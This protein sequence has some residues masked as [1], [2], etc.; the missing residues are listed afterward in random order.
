MKKLSFLLVTLLLSAAVIA[1]A[2][3]K[4]SY[5]CVI[6]NATGNLITNQAIG[7]KIS[8]IKDSP[9]GTV[10]YSETYNPNPQ[11]NANGL[12]TV[13]I[14]TG[15]VISGIF[16]NIDWST[17]VF[18]LKT[19]TDPKGG[20]DYTIS[21][22]SPLLSVPYA[23]FAKTSANGFSGNYNDLINKPLLFSGSYND[24]TNKPNIFDG[25]WTN[26]TGKPT[27]LSGYGITDA[28]ST[29]HSANIISAT[30][31][32]NWNTAY[33]WGNHASS[34][35]LT[36][37]TE[38]DPIFMVWDKSTG[39]LITENQISD[40]GNYIETETQNLEQ[41]LTHGTS[42]GNKNITNLANPVNE[43]DAVT[44]S[45]VDALLARIEA[46]EEEN[47]VLNGFTDIRDGNHYAVTI[48]GSQI[49]MAENLKYLPSVVGP[50]SFSNA[51]PYCYVYGYNGTDV[52]AAKAQVNYELYGVLY[53][54]PA[55]MNGDASSSANP[56]GVQGM[57][58]DGWHLP[59][60]LEWS[61]LITYLGGDLIAGGKL[62]E[63]GTSYWSSPNA[64]ATNETGFRAL[65]GGLV[66]N[67]GFYDLRYYGYWW[68]ANQYG[69]IDASSFNMRY[70]NSLL[71]GD[72]DNM[73]SGFS[74]RCVKD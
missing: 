40:F 63:I 26:L 30:N 43:N 21:G 31:I 37:F 62:K 32:S 3:Q 47:V 58:P 24:L 44:K 1:Q 6:R 38:I 28:M 33:S 8:I 11:S 71:D 7:L 4:M 61:V 39:I 2:P 29:A 41:V 10:V 16:S 72:L 13:E 49:W 5:Q 42:A 20:T 14:G 17:G 65:P 48:I 19:E 59:S 46:L 50:G 51:V 12:V 35:Y 64:G 45:Y 73:L 57:C 54:W 53:N 60:A 55:A 52:N 66:G 27:T 25:S 74:I 70:D 34:G 15:L 18:Y 36:S 22:T 68:T 56:S 69:T 23:L 67:G 9:A